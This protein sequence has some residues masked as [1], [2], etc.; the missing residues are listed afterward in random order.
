[1]SAKFHSDVGEALAAGSSP[2]QRLLTRIRTKHVTWTTFHL[3][4]GGR[5][6]VVGDKYLV[7]RST[8][9]VEPCML[10]H[11]DEPNRLLTFVC[12]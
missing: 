7:T 9:A 5:Q 11:V 3:L 8:G 6:P 2:T 12:S 1:M 10:I 4:N